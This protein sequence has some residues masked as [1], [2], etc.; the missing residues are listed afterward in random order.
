[1][2]RS[3]TT[4]CTIQGGLCADAN[5]E[6]LLVPVCHPEPILDPS[7]V[8]VR[9]RDGHIPAAEQR[10]REVGALT[11]V[12]TYELRLFGEGLREHRVQRGR[13]VALVSPLPAPLRYSIV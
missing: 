8:S 5:L 3:G 10:A 4:C 9:R 6:A 11:R 2:L 13:P 12:A 7:H 1:M